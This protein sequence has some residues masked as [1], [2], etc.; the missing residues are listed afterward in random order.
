MPHQRAQ[1]VRHLFAQLKATRTTCLSDEAK[2]LDTFGLAAALQRQPKVGPEDRPRCRPP[3]PSRWQRR[4]L[5]R[6]R[7]DQRKHRVSPGREKVV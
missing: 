7:R 4:R 3:K 1:S 2:E 6:L 5:H